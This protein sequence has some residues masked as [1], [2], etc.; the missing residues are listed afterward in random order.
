MKVSH[1]NQ[2]YSVNRGLSLHDYQ[3]YV[4][5]RL[6]HLRKEMREFLHRFR[7]VSHICL[8]DGEQTT[9]ERVIVRIESVP[10]AQI[11]ICAGAK[12]GN[13]VR[14]DHFYRTSLSCFYAIGNCAGYQNTFSDKALLRWSRS[15]S[16]CKVSSSKR[17]MPCQFWT[18]K[19]LC[20]LLCPQPW[21]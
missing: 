10:D 15:K 1:H 16:S 11:S 7:R 6:P 13:E 2:G 14:T 20:T 17:S 12:R 8:V 4:H 18:R 9:R 3:L 5:R 21:N 19:Y